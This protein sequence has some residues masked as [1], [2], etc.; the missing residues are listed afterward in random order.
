LVA[1][2]SAAQY[3]KED[4][5]RIYSLA[6]D[7]SNYGRAVGF[8]VWNNWWVNNAEA[9]PD[10]LNWTDSFVDVRGAPIKRLVCGESAC[11]M[12]QRIHVHS[13]EF[14]SDLW[15]HLAHSEGSIASLNPWNT[16]ANAL[17]KFHVWVEITTED[18]NAVLAKVDLWS[19]GTNA[20]SLFPAGAPLDCIRNSYSNRYTITSP[21]S[22]GP[23]PSPTLVRSGGRSM[24]VFP[25]FPAPPP[26][27]IMP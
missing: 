6:L 22:V 16:D 12:L 8:W 7:C 21:G 25:K 3:R 4:L 20:G 26:G 19:A 13:R 24:A 2:A 27:L 5:Q 15:T 23:P 10:R 14:R 17:N 18:P 11:F 1:S 9:G